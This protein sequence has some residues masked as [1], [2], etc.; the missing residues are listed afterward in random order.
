MISSQ[1][2]SS[3]IFFEFVGLFKIILAFWLKEKISN[4]VRSYAGGFHF[5]PFVKKNCLT[6]FYFCPFI[7]LKW[8]YILNQNLNINVYL[9]LK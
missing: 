3:L 2:I 9:K 8:N 5:Q 6:L 7:K 1:E 4:I